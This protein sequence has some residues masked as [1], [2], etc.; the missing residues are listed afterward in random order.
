[1]LE[2]SAGAAKAYAP[3][4]LRLIS[5][6]LSE[7]ECNALIVAAERVGFGRTDYPK[8]YRGNLR[9]MATDES[10]ADA[11]WRRLQPH[12]PHM[13]ERRV[14]PWKPDSSKEVWEAVGLNERFRLAKYYPDDRFCQHVDAAFTRF[15]GVEE[16]LFTVNIYLNMLPTSAQG[17]TCFY[18]GEE[19]SSTL[20]LRVVPQAGLACIFLQPPEA[21]ILHDGEAV[22]EG[23]VKYLLRTDVIYRRKHVVK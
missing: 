18:S 1:M 22:G 12:V 2:L 20:V 4:S 15:R 17:A 8:A 21:H 23:H 19:S 7:S 13:I 9:L 3:G 5:N 11:L 10:L 6:L 16:S 14:L